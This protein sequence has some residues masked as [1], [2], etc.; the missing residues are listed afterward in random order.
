MARFQEVEGL[1]YPAQY[2]VI[3]RART[4]SGK[5]AG[6]DP[7]LMFTKFVDPDDRTPRKV[8]HWNLT[9]TSVTLNWERPLRTSHPNLLNYTLTVQQIFGSIYFFTQVNETIASVENLTP[10][11]LFLAK[12]VAGYADGSLG[13]T[14]DLHYF[15]TLSSGKL[16]LKTFY[17][18][19]KIVVSSIVPSAKFHC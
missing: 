15:Q 4:I 13:D 5:G 19:V 2:S 16:I 3:I 14:S 7:I 1:E 9:S 11:T 10:N 18:I 12:L 6:S 17:L 8:T